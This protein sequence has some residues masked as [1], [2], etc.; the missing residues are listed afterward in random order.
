MGTGGERNTFIKHSERSDS[1]ETYTE[2]AGGKLQGCKVENR[3]HKIKWLPKYNRKTPDWTT[4][5]EE[6]ENVN[7]TKNGLCL[8][9]L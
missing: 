7:T 2:T 8:N 4:H 3:A 1:L 9:N 5:C 6:V